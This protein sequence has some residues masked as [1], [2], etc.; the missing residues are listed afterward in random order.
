[1]SIILATI[2][3]RYFHASLGLRYL[4]ANMN[5]LTEKTK[6]LEFTNQQNNDEILEALLEESPRIIGFGVYIWNIEPL[7]RLIQDLKS[8]RPDITVILGGPEISYEYHDEAVF[9]ACDYVITGWGDISF[10]EL[11][12]NILEQNISEQP[13]VIQGKEPYLAEIQ[14]PYHLYTDEDLRNRV[15][16]VE[17]SRGCPFKCAFCLSSLDQTSRIFPLEEFLLEM[18]MLYRKGLRQFKFVD[19]TFN[20]KKDFT[21]KILDFFLGLIKQYPEIPLFLHFELVP[22]LLSDDLKERIIEFPEGC[23]QFE[24]G[25]QSFNSQTQDVIN[26]RT[27][28]VKAEENI[29]WL[30]TKT[31]AHIHVDLIA[32]LPEEDLSSFAQGF[33]RLWSWHPHEIQLGILKRLKGI[34]LNLK[35][36]DQGFVFSNQPPYSVLKSDQ[37][38]FKTI[39]E[40]KRIAKYWDLIANSGRFKETIPVLLEN[41]AFESMKKLSLWLYKEL[42]RSHS[43]SQERLFYYLYRYLIEEMLVSVKE[44]QRLLS[45]DYL[46]I[47]NKSWPEY[48]GPKPK[49]KEVSFI[50]QNKSIPKRQQAHLSGKL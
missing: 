24:V 36:Q 19:R 15:I 7:T 44:A 13:K 25:I 47:G 4:H 2:N 41:S 35:T 39:N 14:F 34:P 5:E 32:G 31:K 21:N 43:I 23:L 22:D 16:Y 45:T 6:I 11:C 9:H 29:R 49:Y 30:A 46:R 8:L 12:K 28:L 48:L 26:R 1:M 3:A 20:L 37:L 40:L 17:A 33:N 27:N 10:Y 50:N 42:G 18:E 38:D